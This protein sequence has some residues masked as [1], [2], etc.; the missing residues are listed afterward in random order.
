MKQ[1]VGRTIELRMTNGEIAK[2]KVECADDE[3]EELIVA[4]VETSD[5]ERYRHPCA[6]YTFAAGD[7]V[8]VDLSK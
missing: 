3:Y 1:F 2:V 4:V 8:S 6:L 5:P 7:I